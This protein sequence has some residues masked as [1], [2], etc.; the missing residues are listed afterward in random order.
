MAEAD[1]MERRVKLGVGER[2]GLQKTTGCR[3]LT[4]SFAQV[5]PVSKSKPADLRKPEST[6]PENSSSAS[7]QIERIP[8]IAFFRKAFCDLVTTAV[9]TVYAVSTAVVSTTVSAE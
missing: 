2:A 6:T 7:P 1:P 5:R 4:L 3:S 9:S 8:P